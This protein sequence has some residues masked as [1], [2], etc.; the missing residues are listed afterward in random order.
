MNKRRRAG[1]DDKLSCVAKRLRQGEMIDEGNAQLLPQ[2][3]S[4]FHPHIWKR[5]ASGGRRSR[6][7]PPT[8][9]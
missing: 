5:K 3:G 6:E 9:Q 7:Y 4:D 1:Y 8:L 2:T